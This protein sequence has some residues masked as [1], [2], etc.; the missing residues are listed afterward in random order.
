MRKLVVSSALALAA[1]LAPT[2]VPGQA[3]AV[4]VSYITAPITAA[5]ETPAASATTGN[6][7]ISTTGSITNVQA[8]PW[9]GTAAANIGTYTVVFANS[10]ASY[11]LTP[12]DT[13]SFVW[14]SPDSWNE[15]SFYDGATL[16]DSITGSSIVTQSN[17]AGA[18][19]TLSTA[20]S[21]DRVVFASLYNNAFEY[22]FPKDYVAS[23]VPVPAAGLLAMGGIAA[24][25]GL[26]RRRRA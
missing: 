3:G 20:L 12:T 25:A 5:F 18:Y 17:V 24:L 1:A 23:A 15:L 6:V 4:S 21:F 16:V 13:I 2:L 26:K 14:G 7:T 19:V 10:T 8:D 11:D 22:A 9:A